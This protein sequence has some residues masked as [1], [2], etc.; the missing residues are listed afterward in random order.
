MS[1][2]CNEV[3][4]CKVQVHYIAEPL[5]V[6]TKRQ[7]AVA[8]FRKVQIP[9]F[10]AGK[11]P[12]QAIELKLRKQIDEWVKQALMADAYDDII[13][14][15]KMKLIGH[16]QVTK[17]ELN[18]NDFYC[19]LT[20]LRKPTI[21]LKQ[22]K[23]FEIPKPH[24]DT[25]ASEMVEK[26][27]QELR[28]QHGDVAPYGE[29]DFVQMGDKVTLDA[30]VTQNDVIRED[31]TKEGIFYHVGDKLFT[32]FDDNILGMSAG[33]VRSFEIMLDATQ[34]TR[35]LVTVTLHMGM[36][37]VPAPLDDTLAKKVGFESYNNLREAAEGIATG[38]IQ[39]TEHQ[40]ISQQLIKQLLSLHEFEVPSWLVAMEAQQ[41]AMQAKFKWSDLAD[42]Q[43]DIFLKLAKDNV[44]LSLILDEIKDNEPETQ[45]SDAELI[46]IIKQ[47]VASTG[48]DSEKFLVEAQKDGRILGLLAALRNE[49]MIRWLL[50]QSKIVE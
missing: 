25:T 23:R 11:A 49:A 4:F 44:K 28:V 10:R 43:K 14:E 34:E 22:Y 31:L 20:V 42:D 21:E 30:K 26:M 19:D 27:L 41:L 16:P 18:D 33:E 5:K 36:K 12:D 50:E 9:G 3:E 6:K 2:Q 40:M 32:E 39:E 29:T 13:F 8:Q 45:L 1:L 7:E 35:A 48:Q 15:T 24:Q 47:R 37:T 38:R 46:N 17:V